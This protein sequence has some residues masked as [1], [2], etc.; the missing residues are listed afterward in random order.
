MF[1]PQSLGWTPERRDEYASASAS[2]VAP[3][4]VSAM[5]R[6]E[7]TV[8][9]H[10]G[11]SRRTILSGR[12]RDASTP[13][14]IPAVGDWVTIRDEPGGLTLLEGRLSRS[15]ELVRQAAGRR[16]TAQ[17]IAANVDT[18]FVVTWPGPDFNP[19]R[20]ERYLSL[21]WAGGARPVVVLSKIDL[22]PDATPFVEELRG[23]GGGVDILPVSPVAGIRV[24]DLW[25]HVGF[26]RT[27]AFVG[28]SGVGKSTLVNALLGAE[29]QATGPLRTGMH[30]GR[31]V[32][33]H[34]ELFVSD[35]GLIIDTPG[36]RELALWSASTTPDGWQDIDELATGCGFRDC[37]HG[38]EPD[39]AIAAAIANGELDHDRFESYQKQARE[40]AQ[41][42]SRRNA[43]SRLEERNEARRFTKRTRRR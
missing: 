3:A 15:G 35:Q 12:L 8:I 37:A 16:T 9:D 43:Q 40:L 18:L 6:G 33:R 24:A 4:R 1:D 32:T 13:L 22:C 36:M 21:A 26:G 31:H 28:S 38:G 5:H 19:R 30:K 2:G 29:Q 34:R 14:T 17:V 39:C 7:Y 25:E 23:L 10:D 20:I 41:L 11:R 42:E 27:A